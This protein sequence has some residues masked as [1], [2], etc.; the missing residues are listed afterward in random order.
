ME[1]PCAD[2]YDHLI[3]S[4][5][6]D[7]MIFEDKVGVRPHELLGREKYENSLS[8]H[9]P[10]EQQAARALAQAQHGSNRNL[11]DGE[12][13]GGG[14][15][16]SRLL[17][18]IVRSSLHT[19]HFDRHGMPHLNSG[20]PAYG[21]IAFDVRHANGLS[22]V[23]SE[24]PRAEGGTLHALHFELR[25]P[26]EAVDALWPFVPRGSGGSLT[27]GSGATT[28][29]PEAACIGN[30]MLSPLATI[31]LGSNEERE[32][33]GIPLNA[34]FFAFAYPLP[35]EVEVRT[36]YNQFAATMEVPAWLDFALVGGFVYVDKDG[37][38]L[39][40]N[41]LTPSMTQSHQEASSAQ[42]IEFEGPL[43]APRKVGESLT[44][45]GRMAPLTLAFHNFHTFAWVNPGESVDGEPLDNSTA[46]AFGAFV[47]AT[48][49]G[50]CFYYRL[51]VSLDV[52]SQVAWCSPWSLWTHIVQEF[53]FRYVSAAYH[54]RILMY[55]QH[56]DT[57]SSSSTVSKAAR[58]HVLL[59]WD[60]KALMMVGVLFV[61]M[62]ACAA[63]AEVRDDDR[64][65]AKLAGV[66]R[67]ISA[68]L[69]GQE[70]VDA[71]W[72]G[73]L[74]SST[75]FYG[76]VGLRLL[77]PSFYYGW[78]CEISYSIC[79]VVFALSS[80]PF[81]FLMIG[82]V[83]RL[84]THATRTAYNEHGQLT[85]IDQSGL[86]A[87]LRYLRQDILENPRFKQEVRFLSSHNCRPSTSLLPGPRQT[88]FL[89]TSHALLRRLSRPTC[90]SPR[91]PTITC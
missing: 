21:R 41:A 65:A 78:R 45:Q 11:L 73:V 33:A 58:L 68:S 74:F 86:S 70:E 82:V 36:L 37:R 88:R 34:V 25:G 91:T 61:I 14:L 46:L 1:T 80:F 77:T 53:Y 16:G 52:A 75:R 50:E 83:N 24:K 64:A 10:D 28:A 43:P 54:W 51:A 4:D 40:A 7:Q 30:G 15:L 59:A 29:T 69:V 55:P 2:R 81:L 5:E 47:Y 62:I 57:R 19:L 3:D 87:Y 31:T 76:A 12:R 48:A 56:R 20:I 67:A 13:A 85:A 27:G 26:R 42:C 39:R 23:I 89:H 18:R 90:P 71:T 32:A 8:T 49:P 44:R 35:L 66:G 79:K 6:I 38:F 60:A 72:W 22:I 17:K 9:A 84:L 63:V